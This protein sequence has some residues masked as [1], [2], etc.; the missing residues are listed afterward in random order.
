M[1]AFL[2]GSTAV[3]GFLPM[4]A[5]RFG[6]PN[7]GMPA[8]DAEGRG[9]GEGEIKALVASLKTAM[10]EAKKAAETANT[11]MKN[12][13]KITDETKANADKAL[14]E[15]NGVSARLDDIEKK[16]VRRGPSGD[17][18]PET[19]GQTVLAADNI[20]SMLEMGERFKGRVS[21]EV[22][23]IT[24]ASGTGTS[25]STALV[26]ADRRP[27][28]IA[29]PDRRMTI[30]DLLMP[31][32]TNSAS[33]EY[34][35]ENVFTNA[36][37]PVAEL[38]TKPESNLTFTMVNTPVRV[39]A[40][41]VQAS[42]Q[43]LS[44]APMLQSYID[45]RLRYGLMLK[46]EQQLLTGDGTG[47]NLLGL[48]PQATA[49]AAPAGSPTAGLTYI[50]RLRLAML[51]AALAEYPASG[52]VLHPTDWA[53]IELTK[54]TTGRYIIGDPQG[55]ASPTLWGLPVVATPAIAQNN[56]LTGAFRLAA[57]IFDRWDATVEVST[58]NQDNF[59]KNAVTI[60]AE[61]R[62]GLAVYRP[63]ALITGLLVP[64]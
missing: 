56:F 4:L 13:G 31:G 19:I 55:R 3:A 57:Q 53:T 61:E 35:R 8:F 52:H 50:D 22:K 28:V 9:G 14:T 30:R 29:V 33:I 42:K 60:L 47:Q 44:D 11:E 34:V 20:K 36:A 21:V 26:V 2:T 25:A 24:S 45:G 48:L 1:R 58:E 18:E 37:A 23:A 5:P 16:L 59:V 41:W 43:I 32:R 46:E 27:G 7:R 10:D 62:L 63:A 40:H 38:A 54:D 39:I 15:M 17:G 12:L 49:Y 6:A 51:Q 64:A